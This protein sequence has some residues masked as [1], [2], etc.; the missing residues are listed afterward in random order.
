MQ[1]NR[2][3]DMMEQLHVPAGLNEQVL[4]AARQRTA[5]H[6]R[7]THSFRPA[8]AAACAAALA[9]TAAGGFVWSRTAPGEP[10]GPE[11]AA[12]VPAPAVSAP[13]PVD[14]AYTFSLTACA[15]MTGEPLTVQPDG[16]LAFAL[17]EGMANPGEGDFTGCLFRVTGEDIKMVE[18]SIDQ[19]GLYRYQV[20]TNLTDAEMADFR[21]AMAEGRLATAAISQ[22]DDGTWY[23]PEMTAL[24]TEIREAYNPGLCYGFW[25]PP[26]DM[27]Y[28]T[29]L[30]MSAEAQMDLDIF[31]GAVLTVTVTTTG[32]AEKTQTYRLHTGM[33]KVKYL[34][35]GD[36]VFLPEL[37][38]PEDP[39]AYG[40]YITQEEAV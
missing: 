18:I 15:A 1:S 29:G 23:M 20:H 24:G 38:G 6:R 3:R 10:A 31:N 27:A 9:L 33:L 19:G 39:C 37:A 35:D 7:K 28:H 13:V 21:E 22:K 17:G 4:R 30:D 12:S 14:S 2:Y 5:Y 36:I 25:V 8:A 34:E 11:P 32:G 40:V 16:G 26:E